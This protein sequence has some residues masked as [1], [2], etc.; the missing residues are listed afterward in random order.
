MACLNRKLAAVIAVLSIV[1]LAMPLSVAGEEF[2]FSYGGEYPYGGLDESPLIIYSAANGSV[3]YNDP[4]M[5]L[6]FSASIGFPQGLQTLMTTLTSV[7]YK[8]SWQNNQ[9][10][11]LYNSTIDTPAVLTYVPDGEGY[12]AYNFTDIPPGPQQLEVNVAGGGIIWG[13]NTYYTFYTNSSS[14]LN[15]TVQPPPAQE[16]FPVLRVTAVVVIVTAVIATGIGLLLYRRHRKTI[17]ID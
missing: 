12:F 3:V 2:S 14:T 17:P 10:I 4:D 13:G 5:T 9:S 8:A 15:F 11:V 7:T 16:A 6:G 1:L